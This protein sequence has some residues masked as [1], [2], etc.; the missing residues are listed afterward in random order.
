MIAAILLT[1][2][3]V[4]FGQFAIYY[5]RAMIT[6]VA[7]EA[8]SDR[9]RIAAR[10]SAPVIGANDFH[11]ILIL[12]SLSPDLRGPNGRFT[13]VRFY[14]S[15]VK[16]IGKIMPGMASWANSEMATCSRYIAVIM[17]KHLENNVACA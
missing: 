4:A 8:I 5:W 12:N 16:T 13:T 10:I 14:Y 7:A 1:V 15:I 9:I 17:G 3:T 2:S 6:G 11:S